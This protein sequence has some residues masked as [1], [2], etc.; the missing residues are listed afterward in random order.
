LSQGPEGVAGFFFIPQLP[1]IGGLRAGLFLH[2]QFPAPQP[3]PPY[4]HRKRIAAILLFIT[5]IHPHNQRYRSQQNQIENL[6][7]LI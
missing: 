4:G 2:L 3:D 5:I 7:Y 6:N 1:D